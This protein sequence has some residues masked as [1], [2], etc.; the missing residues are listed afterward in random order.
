[1][2]AR[3]TPTR[4]PPRTIV[5]ALFAAAALALT[6]CQANYAADI[7]NKTP[8]PLFVKL[9]SKAANKNDPAVLGAQKRLG[10][11]DRGT[12]GPVRNNRNLGVFLSLDT[13]PSPARPTTIDLEPGTG[14]F[15]V[16]QDSETTAGP[17]VVI[18]K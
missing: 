9:F 10:P 12:I 8:Q 16:R 15:D 6:A 2:S 11:G 5:A 14:Y 17:L 7:T 18:R 4:N 1:M 3:T 13:L